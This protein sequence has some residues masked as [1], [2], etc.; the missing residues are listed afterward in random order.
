[1]KFFENY[2]G[3]YT[4]GPTDTVVTSFLDLA[5]DPSADLPSAFSVCSS[6]FMHY[7][8]PLI[9]FGEFYQKNGSHWF[10]LEFGKEISYEIFDLEFSLLY[11]NKIHFRNNQ[12]VR[13]VP[14]TWYHACV[15]IDTNSG[16]VRIVVNGQKILEREISYFSDSESSRPLSLK[17]KLQMYRIKWLSA[18]WRQGRTI[19][20]NMNVFKVKLEGLS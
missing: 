11:E 7:F 15:G 1:M 10:N 14:H 8:S 17:G 18:A 3:D 6:L 20:G 5:D 16:L 12:T 2:D 9:S 4:V 13:A 19:F